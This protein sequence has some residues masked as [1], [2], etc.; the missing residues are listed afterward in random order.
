MKEHACLKHK[1]GV[2]N[3]SHP[4]NLSGSSHVC[5]ISEATFRRKDLLNR[6]MQ[7]H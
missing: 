4:I 5:D 7:I 1:H 3:S 6:Q 2:S